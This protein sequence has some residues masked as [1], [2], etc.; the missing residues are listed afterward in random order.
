MLLSSR[1]LRSLASLG[2]ALVLAA[3]PLRAQGPSATT[4]GDPDVSPADSAVVAGPTLSR[5]TV[6]VRHVDDAAAAAAAK[7]APAAPQG[8][9]SHGQVLMIV[10]GA[11][12]LTGIVVGNNAGYAISI[13]GAVVGLYGLYEYLQ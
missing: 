5:A 12:I 4:T 13:A 7:A 2:A 11:A 1:S 6:G 9:R 8:E 3:A 10:G